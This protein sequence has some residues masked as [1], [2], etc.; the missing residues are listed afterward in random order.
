MSTSIESELLEALKTLAALSAQFRSFSEKNNHVFSVEEQDEDV[1]PM[2][3]L[4]DQRSQYIQSI[5]QLYTKSKSMEQQLPEL[6]QTLQG[7]LA[8]LRHGVDDDLR[9]VQ[10]SDQK[11]IAVLQQQLKRYQS[12]T[13]LA[14]KKKKQISSYLEAE[15]VGLDIH[16]FDKMK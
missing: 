2:L 5:T 7:E 8:S 1:S 15:A 4:L 13:N 9:V 16:H 3:A 10:S 11:N 12:K 14:R 6:S